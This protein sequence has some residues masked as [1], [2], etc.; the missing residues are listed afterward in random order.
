MLVSSLSLL[1]TLAIIDE[2][3]K[4]REWVQC[5]NTYCKSKGCCFGT[6]V[7]MVPADSHSTSESKHLVEQNHGRDKL[8]RLNPRV[9]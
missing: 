8:C 2:V 7:H 5:A 4:R 3:P 6:L 9:P 1:P